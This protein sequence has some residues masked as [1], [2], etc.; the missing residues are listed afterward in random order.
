M[1]TE[2]PSDG[3]RIE[4]GKIYL[5]P[6]DKH[7]LIAKD[8]VHLSRGPKEGLHRPSINMT[9]RSAATAYENRVVG[10]LLS[11]M[12]DDGASGL[13][14]I[15]QRGGVPIVQD[16]AEAPFPSIPLNALADVDVQYTLPVAEISQTLVRLAWG[17]EPARTETVNSR[18]DEFDMRFSGVT[19]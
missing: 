11:G 2:V 13:W 10:V 6:P 15:S 16:P 14:E 7:L 19:C 17:D 18:Q 8:H 4:N 12:L 5:A 1:P 3:D 9:F